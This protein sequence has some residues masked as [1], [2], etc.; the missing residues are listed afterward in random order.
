[1]LRPLQNIFEARNFPRVLV[2]LD[3]LDDAAV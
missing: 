2:G 3:G 1:V